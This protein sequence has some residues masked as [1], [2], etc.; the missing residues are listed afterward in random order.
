M[1]TH[2]REIHCATE[3]PHAAIG[4]NQRKLVA[5]SLW[6]WAIKQIDSTTQPNERFKMVRLAQN[7][8]EPGPPLI[9]SADIPALI[10]LIKIM[11]SMEPGEVLDHPW[12]YLR[13]VD[14]GFK[15][16]GPHEETTEVPTNVVPG[17]GTW[18]L[19]GDDFQPYE[20]VPTLARQI[21]E[22]HLQRRGLLD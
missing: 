10:E 19:Y 7:L 13:R 2:Q 18:L 22:S 8:E 1:P 15:I 4:A 14:D 5:E 11:L 17:A 9:S 3:E 16:A 6:A 21:Y 12:A 20:Y